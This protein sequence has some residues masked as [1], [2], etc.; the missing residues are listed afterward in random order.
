MLISL[1]LLWESIAEANFILQ[2]LLGIF[3]KRKKWSPYSSTFQKSAKDRGATH[4]I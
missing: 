3:I 4:L 2:D 1:P